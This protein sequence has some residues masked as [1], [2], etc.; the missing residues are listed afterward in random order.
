M[1]GRTG[2]TWSFVD[3]KQATRGKLRWWL[4]LESM[5][6]RFSVSSM[7]YYLF[8]LFVT[9]VQLQSPVSEAATGCKFNIWSVS[10]SIG[11]LYW[12]LGMWCS[13]DWLENVC[14]YFAVCQ[15][16]RI[17][18]RPN[19]L[20]K[21]EGCKV[22]E[23]SL[24]I[25]LFDEKTNSKEFEKLSFPLLREIT[26]YFIVFD[27]PGLVSLETL[28]PNLAVIRGQE[29][30]HSHALLIYKVILIFPVSVDSYF[31]TFPVF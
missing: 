5:P 11:F 4:Q 28:F 27:V 18:N 21:L 9:S 2:T 3:R 7:L 29:L 8:V 30:I 24:D 15:R 31:L 13:C 10:F 25:S 6:K 16:I 14:D 23:G 17:R 26:G 12:E 20:K 22:I 1:V 19:D